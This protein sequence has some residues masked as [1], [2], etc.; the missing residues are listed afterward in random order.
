VGVG[1]YALISGWGTNIVSSIFMTF[2]GIIIFLIGFQVLW[3]NE[4]KEVKDFQVLQY[5]KDVNFLLS[6]K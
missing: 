2:F 1:T 6:S 5:E 4:R 3:L